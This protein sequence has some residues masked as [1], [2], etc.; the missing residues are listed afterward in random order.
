MTDATVRRRAILVRTILFLLAC[1]PLAL[2][3]VR[4]GLVN[5]LPARVAAGT[6]LAGQHPHLLLAAARLAVI[7]SAD[8]DPDLVDRLDDIAHA[9]PLA[10]EPFLLAGQLALANG[11]RDEAAALLAETKRRDPRQRQARLLLL[12][13]YSARGDVDGISREMVELTRLTPAASEMLVPSLAQL[14]IEPQSR[15]AARQVLADSP[16]LDSVLAHLVAVRADPRLILDLARYRARSDSGSLAWRDRL[17]NN[18]VESGDFNL[19]YEVWRHANAMPART[20]GEL[21]YDPDFEGWGGGP[22]FQWALAQGN[23]GSAERNSQGKLDIA[24]FGRETGP[25]ASQLLL[26]EPGRYAF[27]FAVEGE[28]VENQGDVAWVLSCAGD[29]EDLARIAIRAAG[30]EARVVRAGFSIPS[31]N[32]PAQWLRLEGT[33]REFPRSR[34]LLIDRVSLRSNSSRR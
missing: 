32:C 23:I 19:A 12:E 2:L 8:P 15:A 7:D 4:Q 11:S 33:S 9:A 13:L 28:S 29:G 14:V 16:L 3:V 25:L 10:E 18:L 1:I 31:A 6:T 17:V 5:A 27:T 22:P 30:G 34:Y 26:L 20:S 21:L 24:Y